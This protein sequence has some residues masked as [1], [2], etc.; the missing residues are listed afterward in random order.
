MELIRKQLGLSFVGV[1]LIVGVLAVT[2]F[3]TVKVG[4]V[5]FNHY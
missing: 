4:L 3:F 1:L 5:Y 2:G